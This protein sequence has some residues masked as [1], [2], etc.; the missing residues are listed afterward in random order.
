MKPL[1]LLH[2]ALGSREQFA[3]LERLLHGK[4]ITHSFNFSGHGKTP[5]REH[6]FT[7]QNLAHEV[8]N[9]LNEHQIL[10]ADIFGYSMG[11]YVALWL[12]RFYPD[13]VG[14]TF[15]LGTKFDWSEASLEKELKL[16]NAEKIVEKVP[17]FAELLSERHGQQEWRSVMS[18]T[19]HLM[20]DLEHTH[21]TSEDFQLIKS[22]VLLGLGELDAMVSLE[23]TKKVQ[24]QI[25]KS[26][27]VQYENMPHAFEK[28]DSQIL[29]QELVNFFGKVGT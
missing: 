28:V 4:V 27:L 12:A 20:K 25:P 19:A 11:G 18:K 13:R 9:Y 7:I 22:P 14:K 6:A 29:A 16:L 21:L 2:G 10:S 5:S 17:A 3:D 24:A 15:T 1:L 8:L 26:I 23:E